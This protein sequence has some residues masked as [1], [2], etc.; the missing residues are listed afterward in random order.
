MKKRT[1]TALPTNNK[2]LDYFPVSNQFQYGQ[3]VVS[4]KAKTPALKAL[5]FKKHILNWKEVLARDILE[6]KAPLVAYT[7]GQGEK[8]INDD[9]DSH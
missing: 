1:S 2:D 9:D 8:G 5:H 6:L 4:V 7:L 3:T